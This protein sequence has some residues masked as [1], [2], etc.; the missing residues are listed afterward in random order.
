M[1]S[2]WPSAFH[3]KNTGVKQESIYVW[4]ARFNRIKAHHTL[5]FQP[6]SHNVDSDD[7]ILRLMLKA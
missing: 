3:H 7:P 2:S 1:K 6:A 5:Y 4:S